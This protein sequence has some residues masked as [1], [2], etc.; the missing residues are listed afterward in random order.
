M[1][2]ALRAVQDG[3]T[4]SVW[5]QSAQHHTHHSRES[6]GKVVGTGWGPDARVSPSRTDRPGR[7][8]S[9]GH[10]KLTWLCFIGEQCRLTN[11]QRFGEWKEK[12]GR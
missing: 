12:N 8:F 5:S 1:G 7:P 6:F 11:T 9:L 10:E 2:L 4:P 3:Q